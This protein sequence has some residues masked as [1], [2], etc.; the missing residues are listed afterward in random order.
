MGLG[1]LEM[2]WT[3]GCVIGGGFG[4]ENGCVY[5]PAVQPI[6][7]CDEVGGTN[8]TACLQD[9]LSDRITSYTQDVR[10]SS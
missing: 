1:N 4:F 3:S 2:P 8:G 5:P 9:A 6:P 7:K 10:S